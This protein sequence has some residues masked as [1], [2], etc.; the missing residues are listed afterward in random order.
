MLRFYI[1]G[2]SALLAVSLFYLQGA[3]YAGWEFLGFADGVARLDKLGLPHAILHYFKS[4]R[5]IVCWNGTNSILF[6]LGPALLHRLYPSILWGHIWNFALTLGGCLLT[7]RFLRCSR[8]VFFGAVLLSPPLISYSL[9][10]YPYASCALPFGFAIS[11]VLSDWVKRRHL[12]TLILD[13]LVWALI[14]ELSLHCYELGKT[15]F[16]VPIIAA[17]SIRSLPAL[18]RIVWLASGLTFLWYIHSLQQQNIAHALSSVQL[19]PEIILGGI[20]QVF[21]KIFIERYVDLPI[22]TTTAFIALF[23]VKRQRWFWRLLL[24]SQAGLLVMGGMHGDFYLRPRRALLF[25]FISALFSAWTWRDLGKKTRVAA[26]MIFAVGHLYSLASIVGFYRGP[27]Q[28]VSLPF[29][30]SQADFKIDRSLIKDTLN[31]QRQIQ[32]EPERHY[33]LYGYEDYS[34]NSTD[35]HALPERLFLGLAPSDLAKLQIISSYPCRYSCVPSIT[36]EQFVD[37]IPQLVPPYRISVYKSHL[38]AN[39]MQRYFNNA[40][41]QRMD[42]DLE[43]FDSYQISAWSPPAAVELPLSKEVGCADGEIGVFSRRLDSPCLLTW[44]DLNKAQMTTPAEAR[45]WPIS[46]MSDSPETFLFS[47]V[48]KTPAA[49]VL[50]FNGTV[51]DEV[52]VFLNGAVVFESLGPKAET[53]FSFSVKVPSTLNLLQVLYRNSDGVGVLKLDIEEPGITVKR[54]ETGVQ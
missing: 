28:L 2:L 12:T 48:L 5:S 52:V 36:R 51:D 13:V 14:F 33:L 11:F 49:G 23:F 26:L 3:D 32:A 42:W 6:S 29:T 39:F 54:C 1:Y 17:I 10:A 44:V 46:S 18:R 34:E 53:P 20:S 25:L 41:F 15:V 24:L 30:H 19:T 27:E 45:N 50:H 43:N 22:L 7:T 8:P 9:V 37:Q 31:L 47:G 40:T 38:N 16:T 4:S 35:P 21:S